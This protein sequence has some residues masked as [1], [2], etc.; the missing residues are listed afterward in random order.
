MIRQF[1]ARRRLAKIVDKT[2]ESYEIRRFRERRTA[3]L[4][5]IGR[6]PFGDRVLSPSATE[7]VVSA[8][9]GNAPLRGGGA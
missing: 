6:I 1:L 8:H 9:S 5:G 4:K 3:A 7:P 2:R